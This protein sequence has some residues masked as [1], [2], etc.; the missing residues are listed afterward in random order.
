MNRE[1]VVVELRRELY[2]LPEAE[3]RSIAEEYNIL[4]KGRQA[5]E[6]MAAIED[7]IELSVK[8]EDKGIGF[9]AKM[10]LA[11]K[12]KK[13]L[14]AGEASVSA[15]LGGGKAANVVPGWRKDFKINGQIGD[16]SSS[17]GYMSFLRQVNAGRSKGYS[18]DELKDGIIR[19][20]APGS[21]LR[22]YLEGSTDFSLSRIQNIVRTYYKEPSATELYQ[23]LCTLAQSGKESAQEFVF[24]AL[25]LRQKIF[26]ANSE[27]KT[28]YDEELVTEQFN[29]ALAT[30]I[31][32]D[33]IRVE[34]ASV[35]KTYTKDE[36]LLQAVNEI[37][38]KLDDRDAK[39]KKTTRVSKVAAAEEQDVRENAL[40]AEIKA[41]RNE[42]ASLKMDVANS[43]GGSAEER[44]NRNYSR[45]RRGICKRCQKDGKM[46]CGHCFTCFETGHRKG[47]PQCRKSSEN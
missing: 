31:R 22:G 6:V 40:I 8:D 14:S 7:E 10:K 44:S 47:D 41:L 38:R 15:R 45:R 11:V 43:S 5:D 42:V 26:F 27:N 17:L 32:D 36:D 29:Q 24:H 9:L 1:T 23:E 34:L 13:G 30:G 21:K 46:E 2:S 18:E 28:K 12:Q 33:R 35:L 37:T 19:A 39:L 25:E 4:V 20:I 3:L 16:C